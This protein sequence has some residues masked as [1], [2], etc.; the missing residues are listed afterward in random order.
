[1]D[2][3][4]VLMESFGALV[5]FQGCKVCNPPQKKIFQ[6]KKVFD[7]HMQ[8]FSPYSGLLWRLIFI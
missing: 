3:T 8:D 5:H 4:L 2:I 6:S 7:E 1:M